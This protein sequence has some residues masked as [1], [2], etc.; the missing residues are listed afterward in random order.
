MRRLARQQ[1]VNTRVVLIPQQEELGQLLQVTH[2]AERWTRIAAEPSTGKVTYS[3]TRTTVLGLLNDS[4]FITI[5]CPHQTGITRYPTLIATLAVSTLPATLLLAGRAGLATWQD[6]PVLSHKFVHGP[7][8]LGHGREVTEQRLRLHTCGHK[9]VLCHTAHCRLCA[10]GRADTDH[11]SPHTGARSS[12]SGHMA[13]CSVPRLSHPALHTD[14]HIITSQFSHI[15][16]SY[17]T[18]SIHCNQSNIK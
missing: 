18:T 1:R 9:Q 8:K 7:Y 16:P 4:I 6:P 3:T 15:L 12:A 17:N 10:G 13:H 2:S 14:I 5:T 11:T